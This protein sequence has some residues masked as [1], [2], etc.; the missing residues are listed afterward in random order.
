MSE[1]DGAPVTSDDQ[2]DPVIPPGGVAQLNLGLLAPPDPQPEFF[3]KDSSALQDFQGV[4]ANNYRERDGLSNLFSLWDNIP[5]FSGLALQGRFKSEPG[6]EPLEIFS[7]KFEFGDQVCEMVLTPAQINETINGKLCSV[8]YYPGLTEELLELSLVK[9]A[10][11]RTELFKSDVGPDRAYGVSF[12]LSSL[13]T[14]MSANKR[15]RTYPELIR[16]LQILHKCN[17]EVRINNVLLASGPILPDLYSYSQ[18]GF[19]RNDPNATWAARFHPMISMSIEDRA[20]RQYSIERLMCTHSKSALVLSKILVTRARNISTTVPFRISYL[21]FVRHCGELQY[22]RR[23]DGIRK[24]IQVAES[25]KKFGTLSRVESKK[26][27]GERG[28]VIDVELALYGS[29]SFIQEVKASHLKERV[30]SERQEPLPPAG[31]KKRPR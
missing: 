25:L 7:H 11:D 20:Y 18:R 19:K 23:S 30:V 9:M 16:S 2:S 24:F 29:A 22:S 12:S 6:E 3:E 26:V 10:M 1:I 14:F 27:I 31:G 15:G 8:F 21:E 4:V 17:L 28:K 13:R 5:R